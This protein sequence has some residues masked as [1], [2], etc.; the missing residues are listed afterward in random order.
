MIT[1]RD[2]TL[3]TGVISFPTQ[4]IETGPEQPKVRGS[5][6]LEFGIINN[7]EHELYLELAPNQN[8]GGVLRPDI[9]GISATVIANAPAINEDYKSL[10]AVMALAGF[11]LLVRS[12]K[13]KKESGGKIDPPP[14]WGR[15]E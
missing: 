6:A 3:L 4:G 11:Y 9:E 1:D 13:R 2:G 8:D 7:G 15:G 12:R 5:Q 10:A 14:R